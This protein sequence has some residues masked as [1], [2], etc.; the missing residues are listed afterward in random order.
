M[1][2]PS[3]E[4]DEAWH[5][6]LVYTRSYWNNF[7]RGVLGRDIH[8]EPTEGGAAENSKFHDCYKRTK[9]RYQ[10]EFG[11][12]PPSDMWPGEQI[13]FGEAERH[14]A[15]ETSRLPYVTTSHSAPLPSMPS[16]FCGQDGVSIGI[17][18]PGC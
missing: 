4:V 6:H 17:R 10:E 9:E 15:V 2:T 11:T 8:H 3:R 13:R 7:C 16:S 18:P 14:T 1:L 12:M 5:L